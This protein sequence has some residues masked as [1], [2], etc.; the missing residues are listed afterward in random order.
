MDV[1]FLNKDF[2]ACVKP[3]GL[4]SQPDTSGDDDMTSL[5]KQY[6]KAR[7]ENE[8]IF[9]LHRLDRATGG[10]MIYARNQKSAAELSRL[11]AEKD[12]FE[13]HYLTVV[14][15][16]PSEKCG[17]MTDYLYKDS[18][19]KKSFVVKSERKGAKLASLD[20]EVINSVEIN[21]K[22]FSLV[23]V[24][25]NT[26]RFHQIRAQFSSRGM[27]V[28][29]DGKYG[30]REKAPHFALWANKIAFAYKGKKYEFEKAPDM[31]ALP[32]NYF[33]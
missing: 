16:V 11:I 17:N 26:G 24:K 30:S 18:A 23:G 27:S 2:L 10:V 14:S 22:T 33:R 7:G 4:P 20:Y 19:Q 29:G 9:V 28:F 25:L 1:L 13:K 6:L 32:W 12:G 31:D 3:Q 8:D 21:T 5:L 15:G